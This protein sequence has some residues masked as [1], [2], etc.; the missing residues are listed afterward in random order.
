MIPLDLHSERYRP[1]GGIDARSV[2]RALGRT[3]L[4]LWDLLLRETLQ[5]GWDARS[6]PEGPVSFA[7]DAWQATTDQHRVLREVVFTTAPPGSLVRET[8]AGRSPALLTISDTGTRGLTGPTRADRA[9]VEY[10]DFVD[11]VRNIGR[12]EQKGYAGGTY[13]FGKA[14]LYEASS[15]STVIVFSRTGVG[16]S[17]ESRL[18]AMSLDRPTDIDGVRYTGRH[19]WGRLRQDLTEPV[20]GS[21]AEQLSAALGMDRIPAGRTGTTIAVLAPRLTDGETLHDA[22]RACAHAA[23][24]HAWPHM[25]TTDN[26]QPTIRFEFTCHASLVPATDPRNDARLRQ[27]VGAY[28]RSDELLAG[29]TPDTDGPYDTREV[30][31]ER[32]SRR[33]GAI[34]HR[35]YTARG[36]EPRSEIALMRDP[37]LVV[38]YLTVTPHPSGQNTAGVFIADPDLNEDFAIAE[39]VTHDDWVPDQMGME[40]YQRNP[41]RQALNKIRELFRRPAAFNPSSTTSDVY[42]G[43]T[44]LASLLGGLLDTQPAGTDTRVP[45]HP[46]PAHPGADGTAP[47]TST[48]AAPRTGP[49]DTRDATPTADGGSTT[50]RPAHGTEP[51]PPRGRARIHIRPP[52]SVSP[53]MIGGVRAAEFEFD[54]DLPDSDAPAT[55]TAEPH[56]VVDSGRETDGPA[57]AGQPHVLG[58][59]DTTSGRIV[60]GP[61]LHLPYPGHRRWAVRVSQPADAAVGVTVRRAEET[62]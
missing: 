26:R 59:R 29:G 2:R 61:V 36:A 53:I 46:G 50:E 48:S 55:V 47:D 45:A 20:T 58:W 27:F 51:R 3:T 17:L 11:F 15:C 43:T 6:A 13:G 34:S 33:L 25:L 60:D 24:E 5:N 32:P 39:P 31:S 19:W 49:H 22:V 14:V 35:R 9:T 16:T 57:G 21:D 38:R 30:R 23:T 42:P 37:R 18:I 62:R 4:R 41:V 40:K 10:H 8:L 52:T 44:E 1:E 7:I 28:R 56:V 54:I 12:D